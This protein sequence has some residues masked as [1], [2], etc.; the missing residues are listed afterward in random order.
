ME[1]RLVIDANRL[2]I[3]GKTIVN[4]GAEP[5]LLPGCA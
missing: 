4:G 3:T 2:N 5:G 1:K